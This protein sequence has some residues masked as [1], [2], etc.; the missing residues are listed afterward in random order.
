[1]VML[2]CDGFTF[3]LR[4]EVTIIRFARNASEF[5]SI[6]S[7]KIGIETLIS[8]LAPVNGRFMSTDPKSPSIEHHICTSMDTYK[9]AYIIYV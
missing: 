9:Y 7:L 6:I 8:C 4:L 5:S 3:A 2:A 1:M